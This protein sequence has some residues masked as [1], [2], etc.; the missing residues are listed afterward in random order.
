MT[1]VES[2]DD[3]FEELW[4]VVVADPHAGGAGGGELALV[5]HALAAAVAPG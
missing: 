4:A 1:H 5:A 2:D 3:L